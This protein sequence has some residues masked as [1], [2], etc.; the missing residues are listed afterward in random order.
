MGAWECGR[1]GKWKPGLD[2]IDQSRSAAGRLP[3][4]T[5]MAGPETSLEIIRGTNLLESARKVS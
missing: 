1:L 5:G 2:Y 3:Y 4:Q